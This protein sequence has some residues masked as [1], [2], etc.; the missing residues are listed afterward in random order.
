MINNDIY[1]IILEDTLSGYWDWNILTNEYFMSPTFKSILGYEEHEITIAPESWTT[2]INKIDLDY[3]INSLSNINLEC[4]INS[5]SCVSRYYHKDGSIVWLNCSGKIIDWDEN[6]KPTRVVGSVDNITTLKEKEIENER[7]SNNLKNLLDASTNISI[8]GTN[9]EGLI[10]H[11]NKGAE[12]LLGYNADE[13]IDIA[14]PK[15]IH[16]E[17]EVI[18]HGE[19]LS[20]RFNKKIEGFDVFVELARQGL[21]ESKDWTYVRN[22]GSHL[23]VQLVVTAR[24]NI[25]NEIIGFL[26]IG[27]DITELKKTQSNLIKTNEHITYQNKKLLDFTYI[28]SHNLKTHTKNI[29]MLLQLFDR[30]EK[31]DDKKE[32][33]N[34]VKDNA[35]NLYSTINSLNDIIQIQNNSVNDNQILNLNEFIIKSINLLSIDLE[36]VDAKIEVNVSKDVTINYNPIYL[37]SIIFNLISNAIKYRNR[38]RKLEIIIDLKITKNKPVLTISDNGI[39]VDLEKYGEKI[40]GLFKTFHNNKDAKGV[41]LYITKT[42]IE[43]MGGTISIDSTPNIGTTFTINF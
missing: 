23:S 6:G 33:I 16:L 31:D 30:K 13:M 39:G 36:K 15:K 20:K 35:V 37:E 14:T 34:L 11:F 10:T 18:A 5:M 26:G 24:K 4:G 22:N 12:R 9:L 27:T 1:K 17:E 8:I 38:N 19:Y 25:R 2:L 29:N 43:S 41:G 7:L 28:A 40:F 42:Q 21:Y 3:K 32:I